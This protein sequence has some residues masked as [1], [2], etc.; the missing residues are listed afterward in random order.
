MLELTR[1]ANYV[2]DRFRQFINPKYRLKEGN[3]LI[4]WGPDMS[5]TW[6]SRV[7]QYV[8]RERV[9]MPY[10]DLE[11]FKKVRRTRDLA[12]SLASD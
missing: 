8:G 12:F 10:Q 2:C 5:L 11:S 6:R 1:A 3:L 9:L 4:E 7:V